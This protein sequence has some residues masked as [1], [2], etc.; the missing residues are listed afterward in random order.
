MALVQQHTELQT[1][2]DIVDYKVV[3]NLLIGHVVI[4]ISL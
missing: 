3:D 1:C 2:I 4:I